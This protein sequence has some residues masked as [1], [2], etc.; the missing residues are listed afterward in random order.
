ME[1]YFL[2]V[3]ITLESADGLELSAEESSSDEKSLNFEFNWL[4]E[5]GI[6]SL[7]WEWARKHCIAKA[8]RGAI[9]TMEKLLL[10]QDAKY[11]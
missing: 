10:V 4:S 3:G 7:Q 8:S 9:S 5:H 2:L 1:A 6:Q 11:N